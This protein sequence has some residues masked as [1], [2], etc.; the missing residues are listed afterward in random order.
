MI[1]VPLTITVYYWWIWHV[2]LTRDFNELKYSDQDETWIFYSWFVLVTFGLGL[3]KYGLQGVEAAMLHEPLWQVGNTM[4]LLMHGGNTWSGPSGWMKCIQLLLRKKI[5]VQRLWLVLASLSIMAFIAMPLS[6]L[7]M[8]ISDGYIKSKDPPFV[9]GRTWGDFERRGDLLLEQHSVSPWRSGSIL[10][11][12]GIGIAYTPPDFD[13]SQKSYLE[14]LPNSFPQGKEPGEEGIAELFLGPQ[15]SMPVAG[16]AWGLRLGFNCSIVESVSEFTVL[17]KKSSFFA[18]PEIG[19]TPYIV[20]RTE[21]LDSIYVFNSSGPWLSNSKS[22]IWTFA[23]MGES[24]RAGYGDYSPEEDIFEYALWQVLLDY[25]NA[26][27]EFNK[28]IDTPISGLGP[29]FIQEKNG[30][31]SVNKTFPSM[32]NDDND[33]RNDLVYPD[34]W[35]IPYPINSSSAPIG[36]RCRTTSALG[37]A[38]IDGQTFTSFNENPPEFDLNAGVRTTRFGHVATIALISPFTNLLRSINAPGPVTRMGD[39]GF[40]SYP[41]FVQPR[42]LLRA[43]LR[44]Q[45]VDAIQLMYDGI[46]SLDDA[47]VNPNL[48]SSKPGNVLERGDVPPGLVAA[49]YLIWAIGC[50]VLGCTYGF[51]RRW[52]ENLDAY[53]FFRFGADFSDDIR[54]QHDFSSVE[55]FDGCETLWRLPGLVGDSRPTMNIGHISLVQTGNLARKSKLY[56]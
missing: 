34:S 48:T 50:V 29:L 26:G 22:N 18:A 4:V 31:F 41:H 2:L 35:W 20:L 56:N 15:A 37:D 28:T 8:E 33:R 24:W 1:V 49:M 53:S 23:V 44:A 25:D 39:T 55:S 19:S 6:G 13:R 16:K 30:T 46:D 36:V 32:G 52:A 43:V 27:F 45:A 3:S 11:V 47:H 38:D 5:I 17:N 12:P 51:R 9:V 7:T 10:K 40:E 14:D 42:T 21:D 54:R